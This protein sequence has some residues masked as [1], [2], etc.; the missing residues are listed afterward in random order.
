MDCVLTF[1]Q[2]MMSK[3]EELWNFFSILSQYYLKAINILIVIF[4]FKLIFDNRINYHRYY[5]TN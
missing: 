5:E 3:K 1:R 2:D 4:N